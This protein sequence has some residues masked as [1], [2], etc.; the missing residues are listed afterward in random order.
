VSHSTN[1]HGEQPSTYFVEDRSNKE[2]LA[3]LQVLDQMITGGMGGVLPEQPDPTRFQH[4]LDVG[5]GIGG[6]LIEAAKVSP[7]LSRFVGV[8]ISN[9]MIEYA[10]AQ[11]KAQQ[12][13]DR[14]AFHVM[15]A[16]QTL[17]FPDA[18]FDLVNQRFGHGYLRTWDWP[19][20][21]QRYQR[22]C[23]PGGVIR[24]TEADWVIETSSPALTRLNHLF[25]QA[26]YRSG[27]YFT[28]NGDGLIN[29]LACLFSRQG[30]KHVQTRT[31]TLESRAGTLEG[32]LFYEDKRLIYR[33]ML[34]FLQRWTRV[35]D[36]YEQ[37]YQQMLS[38]IRQ[39]DFVG[40]VVVLTAW[41]SKPE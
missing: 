33:T 41:G 11:A 29:E 3:R 8:D 17:A 31:H 19:D 30:L 35:P 10:Q 4:V 26:F 5:C 12:V 24:V 22:V 23:R 36:T 25:L 27:H 40:R 18:S 6:W 14:V 28:P 13:A 7:G 16:L 1:A 34:P 39:P 20:L 37:L 32:Q 38:E 21:L 2:E 15:D 9:R